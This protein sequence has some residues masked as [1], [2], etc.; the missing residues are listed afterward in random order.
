MKIDLS[1]YQ[2]GTQFKLKNGAIVTLIG[3]SAT[4][5]DRYILEYNYDGQIITRFGDG[6]HQTNSE[7][8]IES[9]VRPEK[10]LVA[11]RRKSGVIDTE[12]IVEPQI[13]TPNYLLLNLQE[14]FSEGKLGISMPV[15]ILSWSKIKE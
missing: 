2:P 12:T 9:V 5:D 6:K 1:K 15:K 8:D 13:L 14:K 7:Y 10:Y 11:F 3:K 4:A